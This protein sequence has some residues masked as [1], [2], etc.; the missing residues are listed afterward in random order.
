MNGSIVGAT[1]LQSQRNLRGL[2]SVYFLVSLLRSHGVLIFYGRKA[3]RASCGIDGLTANRTDIS[4]QPMSSRYQDV[5]ISV[6]IGK[7]IVSAGFIYQM[8]KTPATDDVPIATA[9]VDPEPSTRIS[10]KEI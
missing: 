6:Y 8:L 4:L 5:Y 2:P 1:A 3:L 10:G 9:S 7:T